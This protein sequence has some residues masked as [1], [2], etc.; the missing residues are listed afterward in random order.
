[1]KKFF[2]KIIKL[3]A[4]DSNTDKDRAVDKGARRRLQADRRL[5]APDGVDWAVMARRHVQS[6]KI[7]R[8]GR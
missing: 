4:R 7:G 1:M 5:I 2:D 8:Q 3:E 6:I